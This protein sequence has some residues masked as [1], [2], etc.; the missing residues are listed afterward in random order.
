[1][2][3]VGWWRLDWTACKPAV[4]SGNFDVHQQSAIQFFHDKNE[5]QLKHTE[6]SESHGRNGAGSIN[7]T[8]LAIWADFARRARESHAVMVEITDSIVAEL[9]KQQ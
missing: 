3:V 6:A 5:S 1:M 4:G 8:G 7:P 2:V 9:S